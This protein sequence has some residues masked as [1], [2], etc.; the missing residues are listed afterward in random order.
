MARVPLRSRPVALTVVLLIGAGILIGALAAY[1]L[2]RVSRDLTAGKTA[3]VLVEARLK[4][5]DLLGAKQTMAV[6]HARVVRANTRLHNSPELSLVNLVPVVHQNL[7]AIRDSVDLAVT[8]VDGGVRLLDSA[9]PLANAAGRIEVPLH[10]GAVPV[11]T[12]AA[13]RDGIEDLASGLPIKSERPSGLLLFSPVRRLQTAIFDEAVRRH[14]QFTKLGPALSLLADM[15]GAQG[16]RRYLLAIGNEAEMRGSGGMVLSYGTLLAENGKF[17][18]D[19]FGPIDE[20]ALGGPVRTPVPPDYF[21]QY[22]PMGPTEIWRNANLTADFSVA[23]P[24]ME[25]MYE[26][27][28]GKPA[29]GVVQLDSSGLKAILEGIGPTEVADLGTVDATNVERVTLNEAYTLFP[30]RPARQEILTNVAEAVFRKLVNGAYPTIR[31]LA[32]A[33]VRSAEQRHIIMHTAKPSIQRAILSL[34]GD[35]YMPDPR[36]EFVHLTV[37]NVSA[38]KLDYYL[39]SELRLT[40]EWRSGKVGKV[41]A[42]IELNNTAPPGGR[43]PYVFGP[44][45]P[46]QR[47]GEYRGWV[48]LYLPTDSR[49][50]GSDGDFQNPPWLVSEADRAAVH[51]VAIVPAGE[52]RI[53]NIDLALPVRRG[54]RLLLQTLPSPRLRPTTLNVDLDTG[55]DR[56][57]ANIPLTKL[58]TVSSSGR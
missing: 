49:I 2:V 40:G 26:A 29:D 43:P 48:T 5:Q 15:S 21:A 47:Q 46:D 38:N 8:L 44:N 33:L 4:S 16:P 34:G 14:N 12:V 25:A 51:F 13:L 56:L 22:R 18:L 19:R 1:R 23:G 32:E 27:A 50:V 10:S 45:L 57:R 35:G 41:R 7:R 42:Q 31:P 24:V 6:A 28:T 37:Q 39:D 17:T 54:D 30:D 53:V 9:T 20:L 11:K 58:R 52:R 3:L 55:N 36:S